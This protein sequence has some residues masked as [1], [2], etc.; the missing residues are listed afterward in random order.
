M[1]IFSICKFVIQLLIIS[2]SDEDTSR[3]LIIAIII[4]V[5]SDYANHFCSL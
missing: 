2:D 3:K 1:H 4:G 5:S